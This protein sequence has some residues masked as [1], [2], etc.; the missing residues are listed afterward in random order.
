MYEKNADEPV[1]LFIGIDPSITSTGVC[2]RICDCEGE[3]LYYPEFHIIH[4]N[5]LTKKEKEAEEKCKDFFTYHIYDKEEAHDDVSIFE[6]RKTRKLMNIVSIL[7][8]II[9]N[10]IDNYRKRLLN[11]YICIEGISYGSIHGT[12]S[13]FDLAGLNYLMRMMILNLKEDITLII[14]PPSVIKKYATGKGNA[15]K[16]MMVSLFSSIFKEFTLPK[17]DDVA[18]AYFMSHY[19]Q[20]TFEAQN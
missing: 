11:V 14:A 5:K 1:N 19:A 7:K 2:A 12:K 20:K 13:I 15:S 4:Q 17:I 8:G 3:D 9:M 10:Y 16:D 6:M 18:D